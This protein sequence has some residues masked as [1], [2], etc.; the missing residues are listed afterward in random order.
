MYIYI[1]IHIRV[2]VYIYTLGWFAFDA[3]EIGQRLARCL[4]K[5]SEHK[6]WSS[7]CA[8]CVSARRGR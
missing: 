8:V 4:N 3:S 2:C 5:E 1:Y 6:L 7:E